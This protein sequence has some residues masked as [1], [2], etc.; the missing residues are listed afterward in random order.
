MASQ[1]ELT[2]D[3]E[4][5][6]FPTPW[7]VAPDK[8]NG[9]E[10]PN[11]SKMVFGV[12]ND[13]EWHPFLSWCN[14]EKEMIKEFISKLPPNR[15]NVMLETFCGSGQSSFWNE[16]TTRKV[17]QLCRQKLGACNFIF[18]SHKHKGGPD[19]CGISNSLFFDDEGCVSCEQFTVRQAALINEFCDL[20]I[21]MSSGL[22]VSTSAWG[23]K[24]V[25]KL[26][27]CGS[28]KCSTVALANGRIELV[29]TDGKDKKSADAE[30]E[31]KLMEM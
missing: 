24:P 12:P 31:K 2:K 16:D 21:C 28:Q 25:P 3:L 1:Y 7:M 20:M 5:G 19:N 6:Y 10:Y 13:W 15:K 27:Y 14:G 30:F 23:L 11:I 18:V 22:S 26:Q 17:M 29:T 9:I 8:H 4:E